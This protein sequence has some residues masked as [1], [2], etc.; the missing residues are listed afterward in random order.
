MAFA[1]NNVYLPLVIRNYPPPPPMK[2]QTGIHLGSRQD[3][4]PE[5]TLEKI[6]GRLPGGVWPRA[7]VVQSSQLYFLD[8]HTTGQ[9]NIAQAR[10]RLDGLYAYLAEAQRNGVIVIIRITP[11]P[12]N[13]ADWEDTG[14]VHILDASTTPVGGNYCDGKFGKFRAIDDIA[15]EMHE[16][17]KLNTNQNHQ[18]NPANFFF[19]PVNEPNN[20]WYSYWEDKEAQDRIQTSIAWTEMDAYFS[21]VHDT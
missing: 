21:M 3:T 13:F 1:P 14:L 7:V 4:W 6:D 11:S 8:R 5:S 2:Q 20:E 10:V 19:E 16:I 17:Y 15:T 18:W 9:C 12:G